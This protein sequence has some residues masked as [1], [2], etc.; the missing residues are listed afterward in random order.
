MD[1]EPIFFV[2]AQMG[3]MQLNI[4]F[5]QR[6]N[7]HDVDEGATSWIYNSKG[8]VYIWFLGTWNVTAGI[9]LLS[10]LKI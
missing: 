1:S 8:V 3:I 6:P 2:E 10:R 9:L 5:F 4:A 7:L